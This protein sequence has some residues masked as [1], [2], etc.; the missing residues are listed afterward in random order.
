MGRVLSI[1]E[2]G[3]RGETVRSSW[4]GGGRPASGRADPLRMSEPCGLAGGAKGWSDQ[5][6]EAASVATAVRRPQSADLV[7]PTR[8]PPCDLRA[9]SHG[10][11]H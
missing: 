6:L 10:R 1:E 9:G 11:S 3:L 7:R 5:L 2:A 8:W 4:G